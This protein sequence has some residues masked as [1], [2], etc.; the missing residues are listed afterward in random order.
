MQRSLVIH[1]NGKVYVKEECDLDYIIEGELCKFATVEKMPT[2]IHTY[3]INKYSLWSAAVMRMTGEYIIDFLKKNAINEVP[4]EVESLIK[5]TIKDFWTL[6]LYIGTNIVLEGKEAAID[7][8]KKDSDICNIA[9]N[10]SI[11]NKIFFQINNL[12]VL[13]NILINYNIYLVEVVENVSFSDLQVN[14]NVKLYAYQA[15]AIKQ[16][17]KYNKGVIQIP[18]GGGK[19][20]I[21]L[22]IIEHCKA[23]ALVFLKD[24]ESYETW[25]NEILDKTNLNSEDISFNK[26]QSNK[27]INICTY[28]YAVRHLD[29]LELN[30]MWGIIIYDDANGLLADKSQELAYISSKYK[31]AMDSIFKRSDNN[32]YLIFKLIG[33]MIFNLT[34]KKLEVVYNQSKV[35]C[36]VVKVPFEPWDLEDEANEN[37]TVSKNI[38]KIHTVHLLDRLH[39]KS[40]MVMVSYFL[41]PAHK[42]GEELN[43]KVID[44]RQESDRLAIAESFNLGKI[45]KVIFTDVI[46]KMA[47][48][49]I[50][51]LIALSYKGSSEREEYLRSGKLKSSNGFSDKVGYYYAFVSEKTKEERIYYETVGKICKYGYEFKIINLEKLRGELN[52]I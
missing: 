37:H 17:V 47:L 9:I 52:E 15:E 34:I 7:R 35:I 8:L 40:K 32:E 39:D 44:G 22:K 21:A 10:T 2:F 19:T 12:S 30:L 45:D 18:P 33:A 13:K 29:S 51:I 1:K 46:E 5:N 41:K 31:L 36:T 26:L 4:S 16:F 24:K 49:D 42:I 48:K 27:K 23:K 20:L 43:I 3:S 14:T 11:N 50:D 28:R 25:K 6:N 38:N